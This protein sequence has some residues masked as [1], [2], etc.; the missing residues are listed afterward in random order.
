M[1]TLEQEISADQFPT[2]RILLS[3]WIFSVVSLVFIYLGSDKDG[4]VSITNITHRFYHPTHLPP[5]QSPSSSSSKDDEKSYGALL[6]EALA[7]VSNENKTLIIAFVNKAYMEGDKP[8]LDIFLDGFWVGEDTYKLTKHLLVVAVDQPAYD[9]CTFL[10]LHCYKLK[11]E[12][13]ETLFMADD[14]L[15]MMWRR[16]LFLG[17]VLKRGYNFI[18]TVRKNNWSTNQLIKFVN[19]VEALI[20]FLKF[21]G[22]GCIMAKGSVSKAERRRKLRPSNQC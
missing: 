18:F 14:L 6:E 16:T 9:R 11:T 20:L 7:K 4:S 17:H 10:Q 12:G 8:M 2:A 21:T 13:V 3:I 1:R 22:Y 15:Q 5:P 19:L